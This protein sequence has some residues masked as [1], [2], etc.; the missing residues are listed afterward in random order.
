MPIPPLWE[1]SY[2]I[3]SSHAWY[4]LVAPDPGY[5]P[6]FSATDGAALACATTLL[7][8]A[9]A[10]PAATYAAFDDRLLSAGIHM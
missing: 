10:L 9:E 4:R 3:R 2:L 1:C 5:L 7:D 6:V 8:T